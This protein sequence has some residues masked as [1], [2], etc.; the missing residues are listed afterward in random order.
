MSEATAVL[1]GLD[2]AFEIR[3]TA[4]FASKSSIRR[5][6]SL[7]VVPPAAPSRQVVQFWRERATRS[8]SAAEKRLCLTKGSN[9]GCWSS[10]APTMD[11]NSFSSQRSELRDNRRTI[12]D[13][14]TM[15]RAGIFFALS[16]A[17]ASFRCADD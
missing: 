8:G 1:N 12:V 5:I 3:Q 11:S 6:T 15:Y 4:S 13:N 17:S 16:C 2:I 7:M 14:G 10:A 9:N